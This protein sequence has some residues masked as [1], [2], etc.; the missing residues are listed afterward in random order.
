MSEESPNKSYRGNMMCVQFS[1]DF[2]I[3]L[4]IEDGK[5]LLELLSR[6]ELYVSEYRGPERIEPMDKDI[7]VKF[8]ARTKYELLKLAFMRHEDDKSD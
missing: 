3:I 6:A 7:Q 2:K 8:I 4:P 5:A 1:Y